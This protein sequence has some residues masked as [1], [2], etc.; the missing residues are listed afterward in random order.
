MVLN[1]PMI[2]LS[3]IPFTLFIA[4]S[5]N[6]DI[7]ALPRKRYYFQLCWS[8]FSFAKRILALYILLCWRSKQTANIR[9]IKWFHFF[10]YKFW[11]AIENWEELGD[12]KSL[13]G[14]TISPC[15]RLSF[16]LP[17]GWECNH[18][19]IW[20]LQKHTQIPM[21]KQLYTSSSFMEN[22]E[23]VL[24]SKLSC[25]CVLL[26]RV[27]TQKYSLKHSKKN[28]VKVPKSKYWQSI[29]TI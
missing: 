11:W 19:F 9:L 3:S 22:V 2:S 4:K 25:V 6:I 15:Q 26:L 13:G 12:D 10:F 18:I 23:F 1:F 21:V 27:Q 7:P 8:S 16:I 20:S 29:T 24:Q 17:C 28:V 14:Y 5:N